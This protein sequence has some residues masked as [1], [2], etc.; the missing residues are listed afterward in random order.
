MV[1][2]SRVENAGKRNFSFLPRLDVVDVER[3]DTRRHDELVARWHQL[4]ERLAGP[5]HSTCA[6]HLD[7]LH[8]AVL[9]R[10]SSSIRLRPTKPLAH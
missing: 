3:R 8:D 10:T 7:A 2:N 1:G 4:G 5:D 9:G 6:V